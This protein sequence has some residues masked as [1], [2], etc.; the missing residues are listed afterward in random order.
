MSVPS[1]ISLVT[2]GVADVS[3]ATRFYQQLGF[4]LSS[5]SVEGEVSFFHTAGGILALWRVDALRQDVR[6]ETNPA[7]EAF[8]G[9]ALA[10]NVASRE[11]VDDAFATVQAVGARIVKPPEA[12]EWGGYQGYFADPDGHLW[13]IA[14]NPGWPLGSDG[15]PEL[16]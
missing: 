15:L 8:R 12:V 7:P 14:H 5:A 13:E 10:I 4:E 9:V 3:A 11:A 16:P 1:T 6:A 2:L